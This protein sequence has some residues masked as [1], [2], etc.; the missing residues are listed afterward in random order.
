M[1]GKTLL[2]LIY[3]YCRGSMAE[4]MTLRGGGS[5]D[6]FHGEVLDAFIPGQLRQKHFYRVQANGES[7]ANFVVS[8]KD[9][10]RIL[11]LVLSDLDIV[12]IIL[13]GV[14]IYNTPR[15]ISLGFC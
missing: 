2:E 10:A 8:I 5:I 12:Q 15:M 9:S 3:P 14:M 6:S 4:R 13:E 1:S 7:L 11:R